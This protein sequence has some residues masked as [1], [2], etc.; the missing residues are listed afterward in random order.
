MFSKSSMMKNPPNFP[1]PSGRL[2]EPP[3]LSTARFC[4]LGSQ[5]FEVSE[6]Q[7]WVILRLAERMPGAA[8]LCSIRALARLGAIH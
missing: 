2:L 6:C 7:P 3:L 4:T 5:A 8:K 1:A